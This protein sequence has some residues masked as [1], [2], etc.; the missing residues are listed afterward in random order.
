MS[1]EV[2]VFKADNIEVTYRSQRGST[3]AINGFSTSL[4][5]GEFLSVLGP[6]GCGK[7]TLLKVASG[8]MTPS[9]GV[10]EFSGKRIT[11]PRRDV[12]MVFQQ[13]TLLPWQT[14]I[15]NVLLPIRTL[16]MD[17]EAGTRAARGLLETM[18]LSKFEKHYPH[19]LSGG[20]QQRVGIARGLVHNPGLLLMDEPFAALDAMTR[21]H[22]MAELQR[23][24]METRKSVM[25]ITHSIPEAV[26]LSTRVIVLSARPA[27]VLRDIEIDLPMPR[28][29]ETMATPRFGELC[30][31]LRA[32]F[33]HH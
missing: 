15:E 33:A 5:E 4:M 19:E 23:I 10:A 3:T 20:M 28:T 12:G 13:A 25:F 6:S 29:L 30:A 7:S 17:V 27:K 11:G 26:F 24:W 32:L 18:G 1:I 31:E 16:G 14:V 9:A 22:M 21:E 2:P 8:L